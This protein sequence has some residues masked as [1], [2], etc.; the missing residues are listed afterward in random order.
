M[1]FPDDESLAEWYAARAE[2]GRPEGT[3]DAIVLVPGDRRERHPFEDVPRLVVEWDGRVWRP[4]AVAADFSE[5]YPLIVRRGGE[6]VEAQDDTP[7]AL[8][9]KGSGRHR[10]SLP[11]SG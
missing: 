1:I 6:L 10:R 7:V 11:P 5:A 4:V 8:L 3:R 2:R 9:R